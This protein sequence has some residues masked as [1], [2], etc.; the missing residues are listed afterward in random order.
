M[1]DVLV[2][3]KVVAKAACSADAWVRVMVSLWV[4]GMVAW[5]VVPLAVALVAMTVVVM[6]DSSA[7]GWA[8]GKVDLRYT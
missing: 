5:S 1:V 4:D 8:V 3:M 6:V 2:G 7:D